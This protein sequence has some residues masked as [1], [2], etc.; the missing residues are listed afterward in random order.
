[1]R[2]GVRLGADGRRC[3]RGRAGA[4]PTCVDA[5]AVALAPGDEADAVGGRGDARAHRRAGA[6]VARRVEVERR[7]DAREGRR[8]ARQVGAADVAALRPGQVAGAV[9]RQVDR[10]GGGPG[11]ADL[12]RRPEGLPGAPGARVTQ[13]PAAFAKAIAMR[14]P[15][16]VAATGCPISAP[17]G[18]RRRGTSPAACRRRSARR[19]RGPRRRRCARSVDE[20]GAVAGDVDVADRA[21]SATGRRPAGPGRR[22]PGTLRRAGAAPAQQAG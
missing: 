21:M 16:A 8:A 3:A 7:R 5:R 15:L 11:Q 19:R 22:C 14:P 13:T 17:A 12:L 20:P 9:D 2:R 6:G 18:R 1:M 10:R 4:R